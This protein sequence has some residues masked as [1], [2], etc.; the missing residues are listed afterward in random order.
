MILNCHSAQLSTVV[1]EIFDTFRRNYFTNEFQT[2][3]NSCG[4]LFGSIHTLSYC[5]T[6]RSSG[7]VD[8]LDRYTVAS[9]HF[10]F[11]L[12]PLQFS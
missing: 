2:I 6:D 10:L 7:S 1:Y 5:L 11:I 9:S 12:A 3:R 8:V 4:T